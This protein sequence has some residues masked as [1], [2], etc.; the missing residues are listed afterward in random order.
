VE[1]DVGRS[2]LLG[3]HGGG[4]ALAKLAIGDRRESVHAFWHNTLFFGLAADTVSAFHASKRVAR[5]RSS[6]TRWASFVAQ[7]RGLR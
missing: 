2:Q 3:A 7:Q 6:E 4:E 5:R 1:D